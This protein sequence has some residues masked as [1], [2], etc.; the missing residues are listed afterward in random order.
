MAS[1]HYAPGGR[2]TVMARQFDHVVKGT[3]ALSEAM[4]TGFFLLNSRE[5]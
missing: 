4:M 3:S 1:S 2:R 5:K